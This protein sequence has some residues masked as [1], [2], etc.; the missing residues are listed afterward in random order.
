MAKQAQEEASLSEVVAKL[1]MVA[2]LKNGMYM[3][4]RELGVRGK[5]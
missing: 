1:W 3:I 5:D 4:D 2:D